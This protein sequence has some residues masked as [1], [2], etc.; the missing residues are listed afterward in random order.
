MSGFTLNIDDKLLEKLVI[1]EERVT[2]IGKAAQ[3]T[4]QQF[5][6]AFGA[7]VNGNLEAFIKKLTEANNQL[8]GLGT[9]NTSTNTGIQQI[10][11]DSAKSMEA[12][13]LLIEAISKLSKSKGAK[14]RG[15]AQ[16]V[17]Y[18]NLLTLIK[19][20]HAAESARTA[21][22]QLEEAKVIEANK[23]KIEAIKTETAEA[24]QSEKAKQ[25][26]YKRTRV[27]Q[28]R[29][30]N[31][32]FK[33]RLAE[34]NIEITRQINNLKVAADVHNQYTRAMMMGEQTVGARTRKI[35]RLNAVLRGLQK[36]E[37]KYGTEIENVKKKIE[38]LT[39]DNEK[40]GESQE[41][42]KE[43][44]GKMLDALKKVF[45][46][47]AIKKFVN[48]LVTVRSE[49][50]KQHRALEVLLQDT[51]KAQLLWDRVVQLA[52]KSPFRVKEL[53]T[54]TKQLAAYRIES[55]KLYDT[56]KRLGDISIGLG[57][58]M[59]RLI[60]AYGQVRAAN[61]LRGTE[62]R[63]FTEAGVPM[64]EELA[65]HFSALEKTQVTAAQVF[66]RISKRQ[67]LFQ[68][69]DA[70]IRKMTEAGGAFYQMQEQM[71]DT[72][73]GTISNLKDKYDLAL[74]QI[75]KDSTSVIKAF[76]V[77]MGFLTEHF[78]VLSTLVTTIGVGFTSWKISS[79]A[80]GMNKAI[81]EAGGLAAS[82]K[83]LGYSMLFMKKAGG[84]I[85]VGVTSWLSIIALVGVGIWQWNKNV[86]EGNEALDKMAK[87]N[88]RT[89]SSLNALKKQIEKNNE[90]IQNSSSSEQELAEAR[91][92]NSEAL[93]KLKEQHPAYYRDIMQQKDG[94]VAATEALDKH[95]NSVRRLASIQALAQGGFFSE[96]LT[97]NYADLVKDFAEVETWIIAERAKLESKLVEL[98]E[99]GA[100]DA[101][102]DKVSKKIA[103][104]SKVIEE[105]IDLSKLQIANTAGNEIIWE[106]DDIVDELAKEIN[107]FRAS[108][109]DVFGNL[110][111]SIPLFAKEVFGKNAT[112]GGIIIDQMLEN[113]GISDK[114]FRREIGILINKELKD[115]NYVDI[116]FDFNIKPKEQQ[117]DAWQKNVND[118]V[119]KLLKETN[120]ELEE[121][122][123]ILSF[124]KIVSDTTTQD[125]YLKQLSDNLADLENTYNRAKKIND[126]N[127][128]SLI[129]T[130]FEG[131]NLTQM[132]AA[133]ELYKRVINEVMGGPID[134]D[135]GGSRTEKTLSSRIS[136]LKG[137][138]SKYEELSRKF[139]ETD[140]TT[141]ISNAF[142]DDFNEAFNE[143]PLSFETFEYRTKQGL[144]DALR[145]LSDIAQAEGKNAVIALNKAIG[146]ATADKDINE[147][148]SK[149]ETFKTEAEKLFQRY[150]ETIALIN[151]GFSQEVANSIFNIDYLDEDQ[152]ETELNALKSQYT[153]YGL[154]MQEIQKTF[155]KKLEDIQTKNLKERI[156]KYAKYLY[157]AQ[158]DAVK[159]RLEEAKALQEI[160]KTNSDNT[161]KQQAKD[162]VKKEAST[163]LQSTQWADFKGSEM[164]SMMFGDLEHYGTK[165]LETLKDQ[166]DKLTTSLKDL[167]ANEFKEIV[168]AI[169]QIDDITGKRDPF[170]AIVDSRTKIAKIREELSNLNIAPPE[171]DEKL[172]EQII[173]KQELVDKT[174][175]EVDLLNTA[176]PLL[177]QG[178]TLEQGMTDALK[179]QLDIEEANVNNVNAALTQ[180]T[181][182]LKADREILE[183]LIRYSKALAN[184]VKNQ[185]N[186]L[187]K[188][189][190]I[191]SKVGEAVKSSMTLM[192]TLGV[193]T[194]SIAYSLAEGIDGMIS[195]TV[196]AI[197]FQLQMQAVGYASNM[198][199][200][201]IGWVAM[202]IQAIATLLSAI[203]KAHDKALENQIQKLADNVEIAQ[204]KFEALNDTID[205]AYHS[206]Q[207]RDAAAEA[208]SYTEEMI[209]NYERMIALEEQKKKTDK[210]KIEDYKDS[211]ESQKEALAEMERDIVSEAT[212]SILDDTMDAARTF[213]DSWYDAFKET[214][215][216]L[217]GLEEN[218]EEMF[219]N[220]AKQQAAQQIVGVYAK[221]WTEDL[222]KYVNE[223]DTKLTKDEAQKWA[224]EVKATFPELNDALEGFLGVLTEGVGATGELSGLQA[225]IQGITESQAEILAAYANSCRFF[226]SSINTTLTD[227]A[228]KVLDTEG[229]SNPMLGQLR[230]IAEQAKAIKNLLEG[231]S[232]GNRLRVSLD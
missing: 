147:I 186:A 26:A 87:A 52:I 228:T 205:R 231:V 85:A 201:V 27:E 141:R 154:D 193:A 33:R 153:G 36:D 49:F 145:G 71:S 194:D 120:E 13:N 81:E 86:K 164:Y 208:K 158:R 103:R 159:I 7:M 100:S 148:I 185:D 57:V 196:S 31:V 187:T 125:S 12:I 43:S 212:A 232:T 95:I 138:A 161:L 229:D 136:L 191:I 16:N 230:I 219:S 171:T 170:A 69:V 146:E 184:L 62:L 155:D 80:S 63:Q 197:E 181:E 188:T 174:Q 135:K 58:D 198:A 149:E 8:N 19:E 142:K 79:L 15:E 68:D 224:E 119:D 139:G 173:Q 150:E 70:V 30:A 127:G 10:A 179:N 140:A 48:N 128:G 111:D 1:A 99:E 46:F 225:G 176:L 116:D 190:N 59:N 177:E 112:E 108:I 132:K 104:Y 129:G 83:K 24:V 21:A 210:D 65:K 47:Q 165:T 117:W 106:Y 213:V 82:F 22:V 76:L 114:Q 98:V 178:K 204:E 151:A 215:D 55:D 223:G 53:V 38:E 126:D 216:G 202:G 28:N 122:D 123:Y 189:K 166:L 5:E 25:D 199:L 14:L 157:A 200:G 90:V 97:T 61:F 74:N 39:K 152:L 77:L 56:T 227:F 105:G 42:V 168:K 44:S 6:Q 221:K 89:M 209:R 192:E 195:L 130:A 29:I 20:V 93:Q 226:L 18:Q 217:K 133:I 17:A 92:N 37:A 207:L 180:K 66:D 131:T 121:K 211:I 102:V 91:A 54:Y 137:I 206:D 113:L 156:K 9:K 64:L 23:R 3:R 162:R 110:R 50:E 88:I 60:L 163:K 35:E 218:F 183:V 182:A 169:E 75:G 32:N 109:L 134:K 78:R 4:K 40:L 34:E 220:L 72:L 115:K 94:I 144:A 107:N 203:F 67:V 118:Q 124:P 73:S 51:Q 175:Q 45:A 222:Q 96:S 11:V 84:S 2:A 172:A 101:E 160:D 214:G 143:T 167:P 41:K